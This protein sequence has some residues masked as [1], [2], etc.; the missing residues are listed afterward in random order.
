M[1]TIQRTQNYPFKDETWI[2]QM[3]HFS[4]RTSVTQL[5][6]ENQEDLQKRSDKLFAEETQKVLSSD[7]VYQKQ[8]AQLK[9][10]V[11][12]IK[13]ELPRAAKDIINEARDI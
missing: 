1:I 7:D 11:E 9:F 6:W 10:L 2:M 5:E 13:K 12:V 8:Q 4:I 3:I